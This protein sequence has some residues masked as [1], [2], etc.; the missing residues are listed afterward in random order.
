M[1]RPNLKPVVFILAFLG[2]A[3]VGLVL[4]RV[5]AGGDAASLMEF[6]LPGN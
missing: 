4:G 5:L 1:K 2:M 3:F 6:Y